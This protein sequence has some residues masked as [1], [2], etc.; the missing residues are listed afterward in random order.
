MFA[1]ATHIHPSLLF[2]GKVAYHYSRGSIKGSTLVGSRL[3]RKYETRI[4]LR[5]NKLGR[6]S[7]S[8]TSILVLNLHVR[9]IADP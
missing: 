1:T 5:H 7:L 4:I 6:L 8:V 2:A 3:A 9:L